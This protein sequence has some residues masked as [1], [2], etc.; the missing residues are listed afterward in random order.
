MSAS[1]IPKIFDPFYTTKFIGRGMGLSVLAGI[2]RAQKGAIAVSSV[3]GEGTRVRIFFPCTHPQRIEPQVPSPSEASWQGHGT[4]LVVD[5]EEEVRIAS[6][7]ILEESGFDVLTA[8]D[9]QVGLDLFKEYKKDI[10]AVLLDLTMPHMNGAECW[11]EI[12]QLD[13]TTRIILTS[14][15]TEEEALKRFSN[16]GIHGFIQKPY[17]VETLLEKVHHVLEAS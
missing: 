4:I 12:Q 9:G 10:T 7:L 11:A 16:I 8:A 13:P 5:D 3:L 6:Q 14:G 17:Q 2:I 1:T 15:Y